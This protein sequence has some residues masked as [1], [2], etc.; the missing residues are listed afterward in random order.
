MCELC[1]VHIVPVPFK[2]I[3]GTLKESQLHVWPSHPDKTPQYF[4]WLTGAGI[5]YGG[6]D[7]DNQKPGDTISV[8]TIIP[9]SSEQHAE[10]TPPVSMVLTQFH[11][12]LLYRDRCVGVGGVGVELGVTLLIDD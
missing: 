8:G 5:F 3:P 7:F 1:V 6:L 9:Y 10:V 2:E 12:M 11:C 4:A